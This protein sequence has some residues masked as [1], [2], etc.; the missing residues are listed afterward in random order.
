MNTVVS[1]YS[2]W[3]LSKLTPQLRKLFRTC[4][5]RSLCVRGASS[6]IP[7]SSARVLWSFFSHLRY[8]NTQYPA[9][10]HCIFSFKHPSVP[11]RLRPTL[12]SSL[13]LLKEKSVFRKN[14]ADVKNNHQSVY[15]CVSGLLEELQVRMSTRESSEKSNCS[16]SKDIV[17]GD[18]FGKNESQP[19]EKV[20]EWKSKSFW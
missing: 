2:N 3:F 16:K 15:K 13:H 4:S 5:G 6:Q 18:S 12:V 17:S 8:V 11:Y 14:Q 9:P 1:D 7:P 19:E 20:F 10:T